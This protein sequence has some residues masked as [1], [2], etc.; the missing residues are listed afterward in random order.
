MYVIAV[1]SPWLHGGG[2]TLI[3]YDEYE[4]MGELLREWRQEQSG[5]PAMWEWMFDEDD[6]VSRH[7][8]EIFMGQG[9]GTKCISV[10]VKQ[11]LHVSICVY[12]CPR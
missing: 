9:E 1:P 4:E 11:C 7:I 6:F 5:L 10:Y 2:N 12:L 3:S 8:D